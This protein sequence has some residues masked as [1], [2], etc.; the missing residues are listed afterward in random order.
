MIANTLEDL[1]KKIKTW[2]AVDTP[3]SMVEQGKPRKWFL[4]SVE[5]TDTLKMED[6]RKVT[7][8]E[9][10]NSDY[11]DRFE[12]TDPKSRKGISAI[13]LEISQLYSFNRCFIQRYQPRLQYYRAD[14]SQKGA[15]NIYNAW[16][17]TAIFLKFKQKLDL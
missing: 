5:Y 15:R 9:K 16:Q 13:K 2:V 4:S 11:K 6:M 7:D 8:R 3:K 17:S 14:L 12:E 1:V 10:L